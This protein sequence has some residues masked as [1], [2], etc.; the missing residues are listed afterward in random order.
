MR[1]TLAPGPHDDRWLTGCEEQSAELPRTLPDLADGKIDVER[2]PSPGAGPSAG[3]S[4]TR[5][6]R[7]RRRRRSARW[8]GRG[9]PWSSAIRSGSNP[10]SPRRGPGGGSG[11]PARRS[12]WMDA[13]RRLI[14]VGDFDAWSRHRSFRDPAGH[15]RIGGWTP[16]GR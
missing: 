15:E 13:R 10:W 1:Q 5:R 14:V 3:C 12:V 2:R 7:P 8:G 11:P 9:A 6:A 16:S 4:W